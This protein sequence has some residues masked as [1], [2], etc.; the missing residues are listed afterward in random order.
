MSTF[1][2]IRHAEKEKG[3]FYNP[4]LRHQNEPISQKGKPSGIAGVSNIEMIMSF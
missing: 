2:I 1:Y 4:R 3:N